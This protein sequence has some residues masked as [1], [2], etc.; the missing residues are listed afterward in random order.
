MSR[1]AVLA[2]LAALLIA[3][4]WISYVAPLL[5]PLNYVG[6]STP[7]LL[8]GIPAL[9]AG[10]GYLVATWRTRA[11]QDL[12]RRRIDYTVRLILY[13]LLCVVGFYVP[14]AYRDRHIEFIQVPSDTQGIDQISGSEQV[15]GF[16]VGV[17]VD[18]KGR[19]LFL[20]R[21][22]GAVQQVQEWL[23]QHSGGAA[24]SRDKGQQFEY[25]FDDTCLMRELWIV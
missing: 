10:I 17:Q 6:V 15:F 1:T 9:L 19:R 3:M 7:R 24:I 21:Q 8:F 12:R 22:P 23:R 25:T 20:K 14:G 4:V 5:A 16:K 2:A 11:G 18:S 13:C